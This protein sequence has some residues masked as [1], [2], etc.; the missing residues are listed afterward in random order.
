MKIV[1]YPSLLNKKARIF[2]TLNRQDLMVVGGVFFCLSPLKLGGITSLI[3]ITLNLLVF[4]F[5]TARLAKGFIHTSRSN[6]LAWYQE[7]GRMR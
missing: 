2:A 5:V 1:K 6:K 3:I 4:K 7:L